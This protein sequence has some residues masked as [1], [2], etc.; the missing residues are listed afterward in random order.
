MYPAA[1]TWEFR[2][3]N[4]ARLLLVT[5]LIVVKIWNRNVNQ[6][7]NQT[8]VT[9][10]KK[11]ARRTIHGKCRYSHSFQ[12]RNKCMS[13]LLLTVSL[14]IMMNIFKWWLAQWEQW[15]QWKLKS[16]WSQMYW[17]FNWTDGLLDFIYCMTY[18]LWIP[19]P[20]LCSASHGVRL[21]HQL[22]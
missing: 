3:V 7:V 22:Q 8:F 12:L 11:T 4:N 18:S 10:C 13:V 6:S 1:R 15:L 14:L 16:K 5:H 9:F 19:L 20:S 17:L 21:D 2:N